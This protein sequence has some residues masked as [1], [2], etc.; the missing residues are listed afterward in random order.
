MSELLA[1][2][3]SVNTRRAYQKDLSDFFG[4]AF[5]L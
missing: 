4:V 1:D 5:G 3:R 2:K